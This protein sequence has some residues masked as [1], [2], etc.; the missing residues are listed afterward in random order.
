MLDLNLDLD[1]P[2][3]NL[4]FVGTN[5]VRNTDTAKDKEVESRAKANGEMRVGVI[6][7]PLNDS[8]GVPP[9]SDMKTSTPTPTP[10]HPY[11]SPSLGHVQT[12]RDR[13]LDSTH[14]GLYVHPPTS[15]PLY[16]DKTLL[17]RTVRIQVRGSALGTGKVL[18][19]V[20]DCCRMSLP[21]CISR[22]TLI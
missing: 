15:V 3:G 7:T 19:S 10:T 8:K 21:V 17:Q 1:Q 5:N 11:P 22:S 6:S 9:T 13:D 2:E 14:L 18:C 20:R 12:E 16:L 4:N